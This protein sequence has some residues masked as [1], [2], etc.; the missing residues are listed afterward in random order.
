MQT[1]Y[2][3][4]MSRN[5]AA[6][7]Q[8]ARAA[9]PGWAAAAALALMALAAPAGAG[10][11]FPGAAGFGADTPGGRGG[12]VIAVTSLADAG[13]GTLRAAL[14]DTAGPRIVI[15]AVEGEI[16]LTRQIVAGGGLT[17]LGQVA[18]GEGV[19]V[20]GA[21]LLITGDD[22]IV[23][24]M[25]LRPGDGPGQD[26]SARDGLTVGGNGHRARRVVIDG[27]SFAWATDENASIWGDAEDVTFSNNIVAEGLGTGRTAVGHGM[28]LLVGSGARRV[29][30]HG[31]LFH[32]NWTRNPQIGRADVVEIVNN[33]VTNPRI[34]AVEINTAPTRVDVLGNVLEAG[35]DTLTPRSRPLIALQV[36][37]PG[38]RVFL[39]NNLTPLGADVARGPGADATEP[40]RVAAGSGLPVLPASD[41]RARVLAAAGARWPRLDAVDARIVAEA[42]AG[43]GRLIDSPADAG[44]PPRA[45]ASGDAATHARARDRDGDGDGV[46]DAAELALGSDPL[47]PDSHRIPA[48]SPYAYIE[49]YAETLSRRR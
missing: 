23:R 24:G 6:G 19:V 21:R 14:E 47:T 5:G 32:S 4:S 30:I 12:P 11:A 26:P 49:L 27:N 44:D 43:R 40:A 2:A 46:P 37:D 38:F 16:A 18:P 45:M 17:L 25:R 3:V 39:S 20:S 31:N 8:R 33:L 34:G 42:A 35:P 48:G 9:S 36:G 1:H 28:G 13:P 15:F 10:G 22:A 7:Q 41:V 29:S